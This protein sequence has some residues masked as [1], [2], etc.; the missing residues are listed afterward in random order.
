MLF[1][2]IAPTT[3]LRLLKIP[4]IIHCFRYRVGTEALTHKNH[5]SL[6]QHPHLII[7]IIMSHYTKVIA[8]HIYLWELV[9]AAQLRFNNIVVRGK[10]QKSRNT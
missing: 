6:S 3:L 10:D 2:F 7:L 9:P 8:F 4:S 5:S 1:Y